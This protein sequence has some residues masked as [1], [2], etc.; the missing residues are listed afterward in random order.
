MRG[1]TLIE[2][3]ICVCILSIFAV[4]AFAVI[5]DAPTKETVVI[6]EK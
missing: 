2:L 5:S 1:F 3:L 4:M 6:E